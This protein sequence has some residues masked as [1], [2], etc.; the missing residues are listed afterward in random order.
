MAAESKRWAPVDKDDVRHLQKQAQ[1]RKALEEKEAKK[2]EKRDL[3]CLD[4]VKEEKS[5]DKKK[6]KGGRA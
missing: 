4:E 6:K 2:K 1:K 3:Q 5:S